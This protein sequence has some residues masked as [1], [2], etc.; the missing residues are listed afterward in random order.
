MI[1]KKDEFNSTEL[2]NVMDII[3]LFR[4]KFFTRKEFEFWQNLQSFAT[5][6][7]EGIKTH[8]NE[9]SGNATTAERWSQ[10]YR[11][12]LIELDIWYLKGYNK[13]IKIRGK[14]GQEATCV[15]LTGNLRPL[16]ESL[17]QYG[18]IQVHASYSVNILHILNVDKR[19]IYM[20][21]FTKVEWGETFC[22]RNWQ[23]VFH[24]QKNEEEWDLRKEDFLPC[25]L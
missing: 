17:S 6:K 25:D 7:L 9:K 22:D 3:L 13:E 19:Y 12:G 2:K 1:E 21:D 4:N 5:E 18:I 10:K 15:T 14:Q 24:L 16:T 20:D 8:D 23:Y 11:Y